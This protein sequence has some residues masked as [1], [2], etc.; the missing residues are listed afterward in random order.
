MSTVF[1]GSV[2]FAGGITS[3]GGGGGRGGRGSRGGRGG[4]NDLKKMTRRELKDCR[5]LLQKQL[6]DLIKE[7]DSRPVPQN[8]PPRADEYHEGMLNTISCPSPVHLLSISCPFP[9]HFL[10]IY[11]LPV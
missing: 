5:R 8:G 9:V 11:L 4:H 6:D 2:T 3:S 10:S 7:Y 1:N